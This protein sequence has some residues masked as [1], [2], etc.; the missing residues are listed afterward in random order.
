VVS[1]DLFSIIKASDLSVDVDDITVLHDELD[2][3]L[4]KCRWKME[5]SAK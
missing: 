4:G 3:N 1:N 5:G 2:R